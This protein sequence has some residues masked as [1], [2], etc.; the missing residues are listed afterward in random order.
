MLNA[1]T[2]AVFKRIVHFRY[3]SSKFAEKKVTLIDF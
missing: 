3:V 1:F 2:P